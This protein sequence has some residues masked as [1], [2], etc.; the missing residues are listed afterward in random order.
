M[1]KAKKDKGENVKFEPSKKDWVVA[2]GRSV[3]CLKG[4]LTEGDV[5]KPKYLAGKEEAFEALK[6]AGVIVEKP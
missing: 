2:K 4:L 1:A 3:T 5:I 6:A